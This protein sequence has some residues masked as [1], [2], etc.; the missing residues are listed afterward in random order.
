M[1]CF[2]CSDIEGDIRHAYCCNSTFH[3]TCLDDWTKDEGTCPQCRRELDKVM[4]Y[5][6]RVLRPHS[7]FGKSHW[8]SADVAANHPARKTD[9]VFLKILELAGGH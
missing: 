1:K 6:G 3:Q 2:I 7:D 8:K 5:G 9:A 4:P